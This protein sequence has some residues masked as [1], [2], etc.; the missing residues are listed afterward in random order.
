MIFPGKAYAISFCYSG[1]R[2]TCYFVFESH[3]VMMSE[4]TVK[5]ID[6]NLTRDFFINNSINKKHLRIFIMIIKIY[7]FYFSVSTRRKRNHR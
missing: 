5:V 3:N 7:A 2:F 6:Y 1:I 4:M